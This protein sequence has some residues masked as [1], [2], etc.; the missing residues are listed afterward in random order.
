[1]EFRVEVDGLDDLL[2]M[3][4]VEGRELTREVGRTLYAEANDIFDRSQDIVPIDTGA[5]RSSGLVNQP[6]VNGEE[7][8][9]LIQ[10]G[11]AAAPYA[12][13]QHENLEYFH[14]P[15]TQAKYLEQPMVERVEQFRAGIREVLGRA[16]EGDMGRTPE[17]D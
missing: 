10:Y 11:G 12:V 7:V 15:P 13:I 2:K 5:L 17:E 14:E 1:M 16:L 9:V 4:L 3:L 8:S 6:E